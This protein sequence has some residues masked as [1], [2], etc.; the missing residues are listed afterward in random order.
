MPDPVVYGH[1]GRGALM[2]A[3]PR[4]LDAF[5]RR[6]PGSHLD[7]SVLVDA[8]T[9]PRRAMAAL[10]RATAARAVTTFSTLVLFEW[11]R[12]PRTQDERRAVEEFFASDVLAAFGPREA[13]RAAILY[14]QV[15]GARQRQAD[16]AIA[17]CALEQGARLW[18]LHRKD[19]ADVPGLVLYSE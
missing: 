6:Q 14:R 17:A 13:E 16:L 9:G 3:P 19:F 12:G 8:F 10:R 7:T 2:A 11:L 18:T 5:A 4:S 15:K 1:R